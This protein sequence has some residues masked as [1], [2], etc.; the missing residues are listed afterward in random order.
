MRILF[1]SIAVGK[2]IKGEKRL[3]LWGTLISNTDFSIPSTL[4]STDL[5]ATYWLFHM[6]LSPCQLVFVANTEMS[7]C[8]PV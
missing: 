8:S 7:F 5:Q 4:I 6:L 2:G 3:N 1:V